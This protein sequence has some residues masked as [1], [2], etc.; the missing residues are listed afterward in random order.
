MDIAYADVK[1]TVTKRQWADVG[2]Q[3]MFH[4]SDTVSLM[5]RQ[6]PDGSEL[7]NVQCTL[8]YTAVMYRPTTPT[9]QDHVQQT[10]HSHPK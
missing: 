8:V 2:S 7:N 10:F 6:A 9:S 3:I 1:E 5:Y 4:N